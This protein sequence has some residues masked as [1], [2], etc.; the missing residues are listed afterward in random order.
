MGG[1]LLN[2]YNVTTGENFSNEQGWMDSVPSFEDINRI[3]HHLLW[4]KDDRLVA[5]CADCFNHHSHDFAFQPD[6]QCFKYCETGPTSDEQRTIH[7][8]CKI[9]YVTRDLN[10]DTISVTVHNQTPVAT[11]GNTS[12][13]QSQSTISYGQPAFY[14]SNNH[15]PEWIYMGRVP[16][17]RVCY[18]QQQ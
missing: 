15:F 3:A 10:S 2:L 13:S 14:A 7:E 11:N 12:P 5:F 6:R 9:K 4:N 17:C 1:D 16:V 18:Q 8:Q